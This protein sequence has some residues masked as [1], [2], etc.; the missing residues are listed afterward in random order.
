MEIR[1]T[2]DRLEVHD[3]QIRQLQSD[4]NEIK[5]TLQSLEVERAESAKFRQIVLAWM[6]HQEQSEFQSELLQRFSCFTL[7]TP[8]EQLDSIHDALIHVVDGKNLTIGSFELHNPSEQF[9]T[10]QQSELISDLI[11]DVEVEDTWRPNSVNSKV[12]PSYFCYSI[13]YGP[14]TGDGF[15]VLGQG[16]PKRIITPKVPNLSGFHINFK[17]K[18][19]SCDH[20]LNS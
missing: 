15:Q 19:S 5:T 9:A 10:I 8:S 20:R 13:G 4:V 17:L 11:G 18:N 14:L 7:P 6:K 1:D 16:E 12:A 2:Y 3:Q